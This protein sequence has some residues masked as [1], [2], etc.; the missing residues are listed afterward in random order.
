[1]NSRIANLQVM[2]ELCVKIESKPIDINTNINI[3][4][5]Q[6]VCVCVCADSSSYL[7]NH[8]CPQCW[9]VEK[10]THHAFCTLVGRGQIDQRV[11]LG[12]LEDLRC[13]HPCKCDGD[14]DGDGDGNGDG[15]SDLSDHAV[16]VRMSKISSNDSG[17]SSRSLSS[18]SN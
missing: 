15:N 14:G 18:T 3:D 7:D 2:N 10:M 17:F 9:S 8:V 6:C 5:I 1:M 11:C 13:F 16:P 4:C 12:A